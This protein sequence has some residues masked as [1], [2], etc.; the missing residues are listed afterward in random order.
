MESKIGLYVPALR[1]AY[2]T[3]DP[4]ALPL[5]RIVMGLILIP[6][7]CQK[8]F[9]WFGGLGFYK[10]TALFDKIGYH[11]GAFWLT[12][13]M[14]TELVGGACLVLGL[15][16]RAASL[17][18]VIFMI[19]AVWFNSVNGGFFWTTGGSEYSILIGFVAL[20]FVISGGGR[21]SLDRRIGREI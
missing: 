21:W 19:N 8:A 6:H 11:P 10:F 20:V 7:G 1:P 17:A 13:V 12:V 2:E 18:V 16:T 4:Y 3:L 14:L 9:G 5:L 15:F